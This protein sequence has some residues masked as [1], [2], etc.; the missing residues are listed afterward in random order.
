MAGGDLDLPEHFEAGMKPHA[1]S[2]K[3]YFARGPQL[4]NRVVDISPTIERKMACIRACRTMVDHMVN[5]LKDSLTAQKLKL[6]AL[7]TSGDRAI[8]EYTKMAFERR[9]AEIGARHGLRYAE[10]FHHIGNAGRLDDFIRKTAVP[11]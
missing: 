11:L 7:E 2:E 1:V 10:Q 4:V 9:D 5:D 8:A 3:Y 6:P